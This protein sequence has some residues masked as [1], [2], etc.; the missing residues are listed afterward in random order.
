MESE[1]FWKLFWQTGSTVFYAIYKELEEQ[2]T[3]EESEK[4]TA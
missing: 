4:K 3:G 2:K 1:A